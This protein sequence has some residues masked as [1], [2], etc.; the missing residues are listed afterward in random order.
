M[1]PATTAVAAGNRERIIAAAIG[2]L[3][4]GGR[5]AVSTRAVSAAAGVQAPT[6]YRLF[7]DKQGL[8]DAVAT[9]AFS[10]YLATKSGL[11]PTGDP[12]DDLRAGWDLHVELGLANPALYAL[13]NDEVRPDAAS[14]AAA[15]G[16]EMLAERIRSIA[17]AGRLRVS[18]KR[19]VQLVAGAGR[20]ITL[21]LIAMPA[22]DRDL[23]LSE[24]AREA[25]IAAI[26]VDS[27]RAPSPGPVTAAVALRAVLPR[28]EALS[29]REC[30]LL[31]EWLDRIADAGNDRRVT[32]ELR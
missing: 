17:E 7:G 14:P 25:V 1:R 12:V 16:A 20:G 19:A 21:T 5:D 9:R 27:P 31:R 15:A 28:T 23:K 8:L 13:M 4:E 26:T 29:D 3:A 32:K 6:I 10:D 22:D 30:G 2:L 18:E 24:L 11:A